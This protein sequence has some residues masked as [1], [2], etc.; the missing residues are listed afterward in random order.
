MRK[1]RLWKF[2]IR[3]AFVAVGV[4]TLS[5]WDSAQAQVNDGWSSQTRFRMQETAVQKAAVSRALSYVGQLSGES[6]VSIPGLPLPPW[7]TD[8]AE[9]DG[10]RM[11]KAV[12]IYDSW[13]LQKTKT[14]TLETVKSEM[15]GCFAD[16]KYDK[17]PSTVKV[18][19]VLVDRLVWVYNEKAKVGPVVVPN[20]NPSILK[21]L[22]V[23]RQCL[24]WV[25]RLSLSVGGKAKGYSS[26]PLSD[27]SRARPGMALYN[28]G[29]HAMLI[30]DIQWKNGLPVAFRVGESNFG[31]N[32]N[33]P[34]GMPP[35]SR[36]IKVGRP[37]YWTSALKIVDLEN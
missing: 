23:Q 10:S 8:A 18:K 35:W 12:K 15:I 6:N 16:S 27:L 30:T 2:G 5:Y 1:R 33:N 37:V 19:P 36:D 32:W 20:D 9:G 11:I 4:A 28:P 24:E 13:Y 7:Y 25:C 26:T 34:T 17:Y 3:A 31:T 21:F 14:K 29:V 22:S